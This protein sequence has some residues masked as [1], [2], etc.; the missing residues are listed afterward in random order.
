MMQRRRAR[1]RTPRRKSEWLAAANGDCLT[2]LNPTSCAVDADPDYFSLVNNP[3]D[4][5][6][7]DVSGVG[8]VTLVRLVGDLWAYSNGS[9]PAASS[10]QF[11]TM[12]FYVG[13][14]I[15]DLGTIQGSA[16]DPIASADAASKDWLWRSLIVH[17]YCSGGGEINVCQTSPFSSGESAPHVDI[18]VKRKLRKEEG[19]LLAVS[20]K[21]DFPPPS[22]APRVDVVAGLYANLRGLVLLP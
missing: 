10:P 18:R 14:F 16:M 15:A 9:A 21:F 4:A 6:A 13:V 3:T 7:G 1:A 11:W 20:A 19:I 17:S 12:T 22:G 5:V 8:E 2:R